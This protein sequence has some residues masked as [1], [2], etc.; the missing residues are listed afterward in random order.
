MI[1]VSV[2]AGRTLR[3][4]QV[5]ILKAFRNKRF[6]TCMAPRQ[7]GK[8]TLL[9]MLLEDFIYRGKRKTGSGHPYC[10]V[11]LKTMDQAF[12]VI[13]NRL[14][15]HLDKLPE[16]FVIKQGSHASGHI[17]LT[18]RRPWFGDTVT[19]EFVGAGNLNAVK[20]RTVDFLLLDEM[21]F[22]PE[23]AW[24]E[25]F[26]P[27]TDDTE[28]KAFI[29]STIYGRNHFYQMCKAFEQM[30]DDDPNCEEGHIEFDAYTANEWSDDKIEK[31]RRHSEA[32]GKLHLFHQEYMCDPDAM[33]AEEAPFSLQVGELRREYRAHL[34]KASDITNNPGVITTGRVFVSMDI[35][36]PGNN[37]A[38]EW[39]WRG[40]RP[41]II[42]YNDSDPSQD[43]LMRRI[44][45]KYPQKQ[46][47]F[48]YPSDAAA[49]STEDGR[50]FLDRR[51][52]FIR[53]NGLNRVI[54][55]R[56]LPRTKDKKALL[57]DGLELFPKC[58][59]DLKEAD[60]GLI[61]LSA[62]RLKVDTKY[63]TVDYKAWARN[64]MQ[65]AAD[66]FLYIAAAILNGFAPR[67]GYV[68]LG[69]TMEHQDKRRYSISNERMKYRK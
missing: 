64:D 44:L 66:A 8:S 19:V 9:V 43:D 15:Q 33:A 1:N 14:M 25:I 45:A 68:N 53:K 7:H 56:V 24:L 42:G 26:K 62:S 36:K 39:C 67:T 60:D 11:A 27:M 23:N 10:L 57:F 48:I 61:K 32:Q 35:G 51:L 41:H 13:Y 65:H 52:E 21:A 40:D 47:W 18:I 12:A 2:G 22:Q 69:E 31:L 28:G 5:K 49:P 58:I 38:W 63:G 4:F 34:R 37:A 6:L 55:T 29:T 59:W 50:T 3:E 54:T 20:G 16:G 46:I 30:N 17:V